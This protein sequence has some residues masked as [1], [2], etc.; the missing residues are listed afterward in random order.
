M[1]NSWKPVN[2]EENIVKIPSWKYMEIRSLI[3]GGCC[4]PQKKRTIRPWP[5]QSL[6]YLSIH[7]GM[8]AEQ[9]QLGSLTARRR[10]PRDIPW[11]SPF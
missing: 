10:D 9:F 1:T 3:F 11:W 7:K 6:L 5:P 8:R 2:Y 4:I